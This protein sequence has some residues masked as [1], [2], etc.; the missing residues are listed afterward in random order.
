M[1]LIHDFD[2]CAP[3]P[4]PQ[5][6]ICAGVK[7]FTP[8]LQGLGVTATISPSQAQAAIEACV[9]VVYGPLQR[10]GVDVVSLL[11]LQQCQRP[12]TCN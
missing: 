3:P 12:P 9:P 10:A 6:C 1:I 2:F 5:G 7:T 4:V 8:I 11:Q